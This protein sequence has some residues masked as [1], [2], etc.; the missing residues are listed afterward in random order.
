MRAGVIRELFEALGDRGA[1]IV[2]IEPG[3]DARKTVVASF[4]REFD[5]L[6]TSSKILDSKYM[7]GMFSKGKLTFGI[8]KLSS[9]VKTTRGWGGALESTVICTMA[10]TRQRTLR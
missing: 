3:I 2:G 8:S 10:F 7:A 9:T 4:I 5:V 6:D 1:E